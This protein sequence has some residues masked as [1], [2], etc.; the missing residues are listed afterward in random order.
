MHTVAA[1]HLIRA[2]NHRLHYSCAIAAPCWL[3]TVY[4]YV[5]SGRAGRRETEW[6][7]EMSEKEVLEYTGERTQ[8]LKTHSSH[9]NLLISLWDVL[10]QSFVSPTCWRSSTSLKPTTLTPLIDTSGCVFTL[11]KGKSCPSSGA[12]IIDDV[13][14]RGTEG[15]TALKRLSGQVASA[16]SATN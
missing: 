7:W 3:H 14:L 2:I 4:V 16:R 5:Q 12:R 8:R 11:L 10:H 13:S 9:E 6:G 1:T 15:Q